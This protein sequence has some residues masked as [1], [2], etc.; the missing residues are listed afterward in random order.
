MKIYK[1]QT[2]KTI[3]GLPDGYGTSF[4]FAS[5]EN[6]SPSGVDILPTRRQGEQEPYE[7]EVCE[8]DKQTK[9]ARISIMTP[10]EFQKWKVS[11]EV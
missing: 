10:K 11:L 1:N 5:D 9:T 8:Y 2:E 4:W 7:Y 6:F 3:K